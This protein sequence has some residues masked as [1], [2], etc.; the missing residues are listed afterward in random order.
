MTYW[1]PQTA[2]F[3]R[4]RGALDLSTKQTGGIITVEWNHRFPEVDRCSSAKLT[5]QDGDVRREVTLTKQNLRMGHIAYQRRSPHVAFTIE[6]DL[7]DA[8]PL[9]QSVDAASNPG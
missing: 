2:A 5:I 9:V 6:L 3:L 8:E 1:A 7:P 4:D